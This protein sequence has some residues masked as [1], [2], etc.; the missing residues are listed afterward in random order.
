MP[1]EFQSITDPSHEHVFKNGEYIYGVR[2][3]VNAGFG[4]WQLGHGAP[5]K[6]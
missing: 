6:T 3:R 4:L 2:A 5:S 1:Y